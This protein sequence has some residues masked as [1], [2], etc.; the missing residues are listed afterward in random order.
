[1]PDVE[2]NITEFLHKLARVGYMTMKACPI[3]LM[4]S[5][6]YHCMVVFS[7]NEEQCK[8]IM[9]Y[10]TDLAAADTTDL[11]ELHKPRK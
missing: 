5:Y 11:D 9:E 4:S 2:M 6:T 7:L 1:M 8:N 10:M 3:R